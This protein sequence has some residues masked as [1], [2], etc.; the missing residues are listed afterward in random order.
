[1]GAGSNCLMGHYR[2]SMI[3]PIWH[4]YLDSVTLVWHMD[5]RL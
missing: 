2:S 5:V 1:M 3:Y 4:F